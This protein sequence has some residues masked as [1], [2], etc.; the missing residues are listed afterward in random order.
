MGAGWRDA[1]PAEGDRLE[2]GDAVAGRDAAEVA[3]PGD[4]A[5][6]VSP[7]GR[8]QAA[9]T[10]IARNISAA[11]TRDLSMEPHFNTPT[12]RKS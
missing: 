9:C 2:E 1:E 6:F 8:P 4:V 5:V 7:G 11:A 10:M 12:V 3:V